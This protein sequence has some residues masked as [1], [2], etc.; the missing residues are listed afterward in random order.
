MIL[1]FDSPDEAQA[2]LHAIH[3][4]MEGMYFLCG[5]NKESNKIVAKNAMTGW[6]DGD[7]AGMEMWDS[8]HE[9][10]E[11]TYYF[12]SPAES[13]ILW[14]V[15]DEIAAYSFTQREFPEEWRASVDATGLAASL[16]TFAKRLTGAFRGKQDRSPQSFR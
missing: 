13:K 6:P 1:E 10:P 2:C 14:P 11:G 12:A 4:R 9:S 16:Q 15:M 8:V 3:A 7:A 5:Y